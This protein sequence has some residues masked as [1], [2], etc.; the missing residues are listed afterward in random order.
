MV[1]AMTVRRLVSVLS[2]CLVGS[3]T[4]VAAQPAKD[5]T[6]PQAPAK[7]GAA[8]GSDAGSAVEMTEDA[9]PEDMEG[10][11]EDPGAPRL[12]GEAE[13]TAVTPEKQVRTGYPVEEALRPITLPQNMSEVLVETH[14]Q[15]S[16]FAAQG[17]L[18]A[19]YGITS[20]IQLGLT[21]VFAGAYGDEDFVPGS[22]EG[23]KVHAGKAVGLDVTVLLQD[24][25]GVRVGVPLYVDPVAVGLTLGVPLK[26]MF[27]DKLA[28]GGM[29]DLVNIRLTK[30][31]PSFYQEWT[32]VTAAAGTDDVGNNT[33]QSRGSLRFTGYGIYQHKPN[34]A[35]IGRLGVIVDDF[36]AT[37]SS[38]EPSG[39]TTFIR[40]GVQWSPRPFLDLGFSLG[41][42]DLAH[43][44]TFGPAGYLAFRI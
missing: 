7:D 18:R 3:A 2:V 42:D 29:D 37:D 12:I 9:P 38:A 34:L 11:T 30:F 10:R 23:T 19:R 4:V 32:N 36:A 25:L 13:P 40:A 31:M 22:T 44:G 41:F 39:L 27:G 33:I 28:L 17:S 5:A 43:G 14:G 35:L 26:F 24:W 1:R 21:Y 6:A 15:V 8:A 20:K 16:P